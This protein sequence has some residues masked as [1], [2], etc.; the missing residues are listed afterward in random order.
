[1]NLPLWIAFASI[2][3]LLFILIK[4]FSWLLK[5]KDPLQHK[6][7]P[8]P[9]KSPLIGHLNL[10]KLPLHRSLHKLAQ[11]YGP[12]FYL[13]MGCTPTIVVSS[14][15]WAKEFLHTNER[16]FA[17]RPQGEASKRLF[18]DNKTLVTMEHGPQWAEL[19]RFYKERLLSL[20]QIKKFKGMRRE[21]VAMAIVELIGNKS[22]PVEV[23]KVGFH[24]VGNMMTR[25][26]L[27]RRLF[28][29]GNASS[30][31]GDMVKEMAVLFGAPIIS[32]LF[33]C[34]AWLDLGGYKRRMC[35]LSHLLDTFLE[36]VLAEHF[37][38]TCI[39]NSNKTSLTNHNLVSTH[40]PH[41]FSHSDTDNDS[42]DAADEGKPEDFFD[43]LLEVCKEHGVM[44]GR[45]FVKGIILDLLSAGTE[46]TTTTI[47][48]AMAE[49]LRNP[50]SMNK[51]QAELAR[52]ESHCISSDR[53]KDCQAE[54]DQAT[55]YIHS[56][57]GKAFIEDDIIIKLPYLQAVVKET[58]RL[59]PP[60]PIVVRKMSKHLT[61]GKEV[62][63][64]KLPPR[65]KLLVNV[66]ALGH[67]QATWGEDAEAFNPERF[68]NHNKLSVHQGQCYDF[69]PFGYG[70]RGCPGT[71]L[72][73]SMVG[74][75]LANFVYFFDWKLPIGFKLDLAEAA[76]R[77][78]PMSMPLQAIPFPR[79]L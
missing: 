58:L 65:T 45:D 15:V 52:V 78:A 56:V 71:N 21:E 23:R 63:A 47:E 25:M 66:W 44:K 77:T 24:V 50:L 70:Q 14:A 53:G 13:D 68:F 1:M 20:K 5:E 48:W 17:D 55:S 33:P 11:A 12:I 67:D 37:E 76:S 3:I 51:L 69:L 19:R 28:G 75:L 26:L 6:F 7:L 41:S 73:L 39:I 22:D 30:Q 46:T 32:D 18:Y 57:F 61:R 54:A 40:F 27:N 62:G 8:S 43:Q 38:K 2:H 72:G 60:L 59:H 49:L 74:L 42:K 79:E 64:F 35:H 34:L 31:F 4:G 16:D 9:P 36:D 29:D 10:L